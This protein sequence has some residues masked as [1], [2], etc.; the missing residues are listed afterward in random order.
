ML[1]FFEKI[2]IGTIIGFVLFTLMAYG[3]LII[4]AS[5]LLIPIFGL[6]SLFCTKN[7]FRS[8]MN[9]SA[10]DCGVSLRASSSLKHSPPQQVFDPEIS[11][12]KAARYSGFR[13]NLDLLPKKQLIF[14]FFVFIFVA[15]V[16]L[17]VFPVWQIRILGNSINEVRSLTE[18]KTGYIEAVSVHSLS[19]ER[20][21][22]WH[23]SICF[24]MV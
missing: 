19:P 5:F 13:I 14:L 12:Q 7:I 15:A 23:L 10:A 1:T 21:E 17:A 4:N 11:D 16:S 2:T 22:P 3:L 18:R 6:M 8:K 9:Y 20:A 24:S